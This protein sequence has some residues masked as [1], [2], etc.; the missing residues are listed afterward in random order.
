MSMAALPLL[1]KRLLH[2][3]QQSP[4]SDNYMIP[5][6]S[7]RALRPVL[8]EAFVSMLAICSSVL[9]K[10]ALANFFLIFLL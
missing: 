5:K 8:L 3:L 2:L 7:R 9:I 4:L 1:N 6:L 10:H